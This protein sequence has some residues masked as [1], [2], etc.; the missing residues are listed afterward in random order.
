MDEYD[1]RVETIGP[2]QEIKVLEGVQEAFLARLEA[3]G[4]IAGA[5]GFTTDR[6]VGVA[7][8]VEAR[9]REE[10]GSGLVGAAMHALLAIGYEQWGTVQVSSVTRADEE[11][12]AWPEASNQ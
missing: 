8:T 1:V 7:A 10:A 11:E 6:G 2:P 3:Y 4:G 12:I 5:A 9:S